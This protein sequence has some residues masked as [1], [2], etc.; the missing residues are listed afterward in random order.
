MVVVLP[1]WWI[2]IASGKVLEFRPAGRARIDQNGT[3]AVSRTASLTTPFGL[4]SRPRTFKK[5]NI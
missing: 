5:I 2:A 4:M 1:E 3:I